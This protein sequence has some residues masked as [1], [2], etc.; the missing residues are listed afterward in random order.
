M[1]HIAC[2]LMA[3]ASLLAQQGQEPPGDIT[4][5]LRF[6]SG[7]AEFRAG[8]PILVNIVASATTPGKYNVARLAWPPVEFV[9]VDSSLQAQDPLR[10]T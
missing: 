7:R 9:R 10:T 5:E 8:E 4:I 1:R 3:A 6:A 2:L